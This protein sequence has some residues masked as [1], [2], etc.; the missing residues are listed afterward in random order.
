MENT[1]HLTSNLASGK[2]TKDQ[3]NVEFS[4]VLASFQFLGLLQKDPEDWFKGGVDTDRFDQLVKD[5]DTARAEALA[6]KEAGDKAR[7]GELFQKS[8]AI[9]DELADEGVV[10]E[11]GADGSNWRRG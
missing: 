3:S 8:D 5:Y 10:I 6:A 4:K 11:T 2:L 7:M 1:K 9:R